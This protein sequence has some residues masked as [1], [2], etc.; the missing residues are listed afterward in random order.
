MKPKLLFLITFLAMAGGS[1][2]AQ[3]TQNVKGAYG[4]GSPASSNVVGDV[5]SRYIDQCASPPVEWIITAINPNGLGNGVPTA[6]WTQGGSSSGGGGPLTQVVQSGLLAEYRMLPTETPAALVDYSGNGNNATG[7]VGVAPTIIAGSGGVQ[8]VKTGAI[9]LP[10]ALN[11]ALTIQILMNASGIS[12]SPIFGS[13]GVAANSAGLVISFGAGNFTLQSCMGYTGQ[14]IYIRNINAAGSTLV[15]FASETIT[16]AGATPTTVAAN[17]T[18]ILQ[19][20]LVSSAAAGCNWS[21][22]Q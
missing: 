13:T 2:S 7:T 9:Q 21:R 19:S 22:I 17:T 1:L 5:G 6:T 20:Q 4:C 16:G 8:F 10:A 3:G 18:A 12:G 14:N 15:P 11:S